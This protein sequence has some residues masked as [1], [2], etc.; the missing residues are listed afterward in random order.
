MRADNVVITV[1]V[2][3]SC[4]HVKGASRGGAEDVAGEAG[5]AVVNVDAYGVG[6]ALCD[7]KVHVAVAVKVGDCDASGIRH[8]TGHQGGAERAVA[9]VVEVNSHGT[10]GRKRGHNV[11]EAI[12]VEVANRH[13]PRPCQGRTASRHEEVRSKSA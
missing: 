10:V 1:V 2:H 13:A 3:V 12:I 4:C 8:R 11:H 6:A 7:H 5:R 9:G